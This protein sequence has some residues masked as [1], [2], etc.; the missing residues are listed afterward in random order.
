MI[1]IH[2]S[3]MSISNTEKK[4]PLYNEKGMLI[5]DVSYNLYDR[6]EMIGH[7]QISSSRETGTPW[8]INVR[9]AYNNVSSGIVHL[10][11]NGQF[12][13]NNY[14]N[15]TCLNGPL[16]KYGVLHSMFFMDILTRDPTKEYSIHVYRDGIDVD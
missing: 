2:M 4:K 5:S 8:I 9:D 3:K 15:R 10:G 11:D 14:E 12:V 7:V 6:G 13:T 1:D 16:H